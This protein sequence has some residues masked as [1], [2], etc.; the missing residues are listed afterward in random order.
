MTFRDIS[1]MLG[2]ENITYPGDPEFRREAPGPQV[3]EALQITICAH[4][5]THLDAPAHFFPEGRRLDDYPAEY[6]IMPAQVVEILDPSAVRA[7]DL[8]GVVTNPG[9]AILFRTGNSHSG[10][11]CTGRFTEDYVYIAEDAAHWCVNRQLRLVGH[12]YI[13]LDH[14]GDHDTPAHKIILGAGLLALEG[15]NLANVPAGR[16]TLICLPLRIKGAEASPV[17]AVL[18]SNNNWTQGGS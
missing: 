2:E 10:R 9:E 14:Y 4:S 5:G 7:S 15:V 8:Q 11:V 3:A 6:F 18:A 12:D 16:Y 13:S 1:V 17:R